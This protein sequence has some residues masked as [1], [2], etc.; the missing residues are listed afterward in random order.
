M[1]PD[2]EYHYPTYSEQVT[3]YAALKAV[4]GADT[5]TVTLHAGS[6]FASLYLYEYRGAASGSFDVGGAQ[7]QSNTTTISSPFVNPTSTVEL[8]L[9]INSIANPTTTIV[10]AGTGFTLKT[11][12]TMSNNTQVFMEDQNQYITGSVAATWSTNIAASSTAMIVT[13]K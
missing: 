7:T 12:S 6:G 5:T 1:D 9:G 4:A 10:S 3:V 11:S 8:L 13:F 2:R